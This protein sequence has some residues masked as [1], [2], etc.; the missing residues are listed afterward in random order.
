VVD[1]FDDKDVTVTKSVSDDRE[2]HDRTTR[3]PSNGSKSDRAIRYEAQIIAKRYGKSL[4]DAMEIAKR[5]L[6]AKSTADN[7]KRDARRNETRIRAQQRFDRRKK[8]DYPY[9]LHGPGLQGGIPGLG[10]RK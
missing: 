7:R 8:P 4:D 3:R 5:L 6:A 10:K 1:E 2:S 9:H